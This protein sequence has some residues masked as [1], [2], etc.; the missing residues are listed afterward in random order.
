MLG[1]ELFCSKC[2][3][4]VPLDEVGN[5]S[6]CVACGNAVFVPA[7]WLDWDATLTENDRKMLKSYKI[8]IA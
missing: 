1:A 4:A 7:K 3:L 6:P 5:L 8:S 2:G